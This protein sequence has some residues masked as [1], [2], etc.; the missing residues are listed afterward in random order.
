MNQHTF[1]HSV[2]DRSTR[3]MQQ[4]LNDIMQKWC[5][6]P[7]PIWK[8]DHHGY[9]P[10]ARHVTLTFRNAPTRQ[11][12]SQGGALSQ[13]RSDLIEA[14]EQHSDHSLRI[15]ICAITFTDLDADTTF[16]QP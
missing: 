10:T 11:E 3:I 15:E 5:D 16:L 6:S 12:A 4:A 14:V 1:T 13:M 7:T 9:E 2:E 8:A